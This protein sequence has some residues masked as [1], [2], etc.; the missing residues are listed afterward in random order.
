MSMARHYSLACENDDIIDD[1]RFYEAERLAKVYKAKGRKHIVINVQDE[2]YDLI[3][4]WKFVGDKL[5]Y[6]GR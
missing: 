2:G 6:S 4:I 3:G 1:L 5:A